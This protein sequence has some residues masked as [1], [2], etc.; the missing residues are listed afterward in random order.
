MNKHIPSERSF[1][2]SVGLVC[3][4]AGAVSWWRGHVSLGA[5]LALSGLV[6]VA[7]GLIAPGTLRI[8]NR[9]WWRFAQALGWV[10]ARILLTAFFVVV[11]TPV[12]CTMRLFGRNLLRPAKT[13]T[14]WSSYTVRRRDTRHYEHLF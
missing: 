2:L 1:G 3:L 14:T 12:G 13:G 8:P 11:I 7:G 5:A 6:L 4:A 10:N 9:I